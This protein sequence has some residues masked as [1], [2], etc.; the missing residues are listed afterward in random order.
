MKEEQALWTVTDSTGRE[1]GT[2]DRSKASDVLDAV[3]CGNPDLEW[4]GMTLME[5]ST[6]QHDANHRAA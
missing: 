4:V 5:P 1:H 2:F 3:W 6:A